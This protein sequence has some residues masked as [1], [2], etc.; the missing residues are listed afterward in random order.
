[1]I[2]KIRIRGYRIYDDFTLCP[3]AKLNLIVGA[4]ESGKSTLMEAVALALTGRINGR[5]AIEELNPY[6]FNQS[7]VAQFVAQRSA[8][9][10][11][12]LP[13]ID[14]ELFFDDRDEIQDLCG[15]INS[16]MPTHACP[17]VTLSVLPNPEYGEEIEAWVSEGLSS[18]L[19]VEYYKVEWRSFADA[20]LTARPK[21][22]ATA[23]IDSRTVRSSS[24]VDY[25]MQQILSDYLEP[26]ERAEISIAYRKVKEG[27]SAT[28]FAKIN[29]RMTDIHSSLHDKPI[30]LAMDQSSRT[31]WQ[32]SVTPHVD[33][34]PFAMSGQ[35]QQASIKIALAM[36][37]QSERANFVMVEEPENHLTHTSLNTL[38][39]RID[40]LKGEHQQLFITTHS[41]FV[42]NRL[43]L[44]TLLL[45]EKGAQQRMSTLSADTVGYFR[46]LPGY[47][48]LRLALADKVVLVEG[49]S[50]EIVFERIF[51]DLYEARPIECGI[52]VLSM[53]GLSLSRCLEL[54]AAVD[55]TVAAVRDNDGID[56][57]SLRQPVEEWLAE[58]KRELFIGAADKGVTLE[59][60]I[61]SHND[62]DTLRG[63]LRL[64]GRADIATWMTREKTEGA[65]R[66]A[67]ADQAISPPEYLRLA[68]QFI[69]D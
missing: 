38:L 56:P 18:L 64:T 25:H 55:K 51:R 22:L 44:D 30:S 62:T 23:V 11:G 60:Q 12:S 8:G 7:I 3:N 68:A 1:M 5:R 26:P 66:I 65:I 24:G 15:A 17:G 34:L 58:G 42:L 33:D 20:L 47:D 45:I 32:G 57:A 53:R 10:R 4:N 59:S 19:P 29:E 6:W 36:S 2:S 63:I 14:I 13:R 48:T 16:A 40:D 9:Q 35:G 54:C 61:I 49:P 41:S 50:D 39:K 21:H 28:A 31:S 69:H 46:K 52:D 67:D 27:M 43:G 37:R